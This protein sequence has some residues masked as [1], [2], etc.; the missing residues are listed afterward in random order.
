MSMRVRIHKQALELI[1]ELKYSITRLDVLDGDFDI[2][3]IILGQIKERL[4]ELGFRDL[5]YR[6]EGYE[7]DEFIV[8]ANATNE[9]LINK[10]KLERVTGHRS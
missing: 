9:A 2:T 5:S 10:Y 6:I 4:I 3:I 1:M 8:Y 7:D